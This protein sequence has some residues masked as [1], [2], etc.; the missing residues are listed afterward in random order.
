MKSFCILLSHWLLFIALPYFG[1][2]SLALWTHLQNSINKNLPYCKIKVIFKSPTCLSNFFR[3]KH[4]VSFNLHSN[5]A[6]K[7][8]CD[9]W[10]ATY[11]SETCRHWRVGE[12]SGVLPLTGKKS[13]SQTTTVDKDHTLFCDHVVSLED[14]KILKTSNFLNTDGRSPHRVANFLNNLKWRSYTVSRLPI[15]FWGLVVC[16]Y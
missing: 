10:N 3:F 13:K 5:V 8:S 7:F 9:R 15:T 1:N 6:D 11:Y 16:G 12:H 2:L 4:K 14:F